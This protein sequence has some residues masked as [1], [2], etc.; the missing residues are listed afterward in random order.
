M[1]AKHDGMV[2]EP[3]LATALRA[4]VM[5]ATAFAFAWPIAQPWAAGAAALGGCVGALAGAG[6]AR[7]RLRTP[8]LVLGFAALLL[9]AWGLRASVV[10]TNLLAPSLGPGRALDLGDALFFGFAALGTLGTL[11]ALSARHRVASIFELLVVGLA[12]ANLVA[13]HRMGAI[14]RPHDLADPILAA[15]GDPTI[16]FLAVGAVATGVMVLLL[17]SERGLLRSGVDLLVVVGLLLL[18][19]G[20]THMLRM[21]SPPPT[22]GGLGLRPNDESGQGQNHGQGGH[23]QSRDD[24]LQFRD[25]Y[26]QSNDN[27]P[28]GV[29][30]LHDDYSPP[31]GVYYLRQNAFSQYNGRRLVGTTRPDADRDL[32][33]SFP[34]TR[35]DVPETPPLG[36]NR[37]LVRTTVALLAEHTRPMGLEAPLRFEPAQNPDP[38][39]FVRVYDITSAALTADAAAMLGATAG[40]S[41]WSPDL[42]RYYTQ[43]PDDPRY[44]ALANQILDESLPAEMRHVP[45]A[46][47]LALMDWLGAVGTYSLRSRHA[48]AEDPTADFLFGDRIGYCVHFSHAATFLARSVGLPAR[49][50]SGYALE[51]AQ[52]QGGSA[53]LIAGDRAHAWPE[54]Y[55]E[56]YGWVVFDVSP[57]TVA[58]P[59]PSPPD[60]ELQRLLGELAR[61]QSVAPPDASPVPEMVRAARRVG[62]SAAT[63]GGLGLALVLL[64]L[65][66]WKSWRRL[67]PLFSSEAALPRVVYRA[68]LDRLS[69][70]SRRRR[71][72]ESRE[73]FATRLASELPTFEGLTRAHLASAFGGRLRLERA[74]YRELAGLLGR[75]RRASFAV[76]RRALALF[77]PF[78]FLWSR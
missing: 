45:V 48:N 58:T 60:P 23:G 2:E 33:A 26:D 63:Y 15:G 66:L 24:D 47:I 70:L 13:A 5:A 44:A 10:S 68:E 11:R 7:T 49:V 53:L 34:S 1:K 17:L 67:A 40:S 16:V 31:S 30:L 21:P 55:L 43:G 74:R 56:G 19:F 9:V 18:L 71:R 6:A 41:S 4:A 42:F 46:E 32:V 54:F 75:E 52:R 35:I 50:G 29:V 51:E 59:P 14:D 57:R 39:R 65:F 3:W 38:D 76:W 77:D 62:S 25:Q 27:V 36:A 73:A 37:T 22:G 20:T 61:G 78:S 8:A 12:F 69:E 28:V 72:G 64:V